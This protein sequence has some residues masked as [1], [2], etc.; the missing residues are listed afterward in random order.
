ML[1][2][3][4]ISC[5]VSDAMCSVLFKVLK[6]Q[7]HLIF[8]AILWRCCCL[9]LHGLQHARIPCPSLS[10]WVCS[11]SCPLSWWCH[12]TISSSVITCSSCSQSF[13]ASGSC[14]VSQLFASGSQ[15]TGAFSISPSSEYSGLISFRIDWFDLP[16]QGTLKSLL[17]DHNLK[18]S[19][20]QCSAF[21]IVRLSHPYMTTRRTIALTYMDLCWQSG[22]SA[23]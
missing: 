23:F 17:Q 11:N 20:L 18:A 15:S 19:I 12:P 14:P 5:Y 1:S 8:I 2:N 7:V 6:T 22:V 10:P 13:P 9:G 16:V 4:F 3:L 21:F